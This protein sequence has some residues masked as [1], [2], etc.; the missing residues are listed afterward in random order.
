MANSRLVLLAAIAL[1]AISSG[2]NGGITNP[3]QQLN[4]GALS[5]DF[6]DGTELLV[7]SGTTYSISSDSSSYIITAT[8]NLSDANAGD[9]VT[10]TVPIET[11]A[12]YTV[13]APP[14][15]AQVTYY[16]NAESPA[17]FYGNSAQGGCSITITQTYPTLMGTFSALEVS[18]NPADTT[19]LRNG[20]FN[21]TQ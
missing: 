8:D 21:A 7:Q 14:D 16:D 4:A 12:P 19:S 10:L 18:A 2:C 17:Q 13:N 5:V 6:P 20:T 3:M 15:A 11:S 1:I 9:E